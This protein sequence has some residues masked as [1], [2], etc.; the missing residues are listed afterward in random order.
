MSY[1]WLNGVDSSINFG[2]VNNNTNNN[3]NQ[4]GNNYN[5]YQQ[6]N[7]NQIQPLNSANANRPVP[8]P[9]LPNRQEQ[10][11]SNYNNNIQPNNQIS[12]VYGLTNNIHS[13]I[14]PEQ[15][16]PLPTSNSNSNNP[17]F[18][19]ALYANNTSGSSLIQQPQIPPQVTTSNSFD[20]IYGNQYLNANLSGGSNSN[21]T[22]INYRPP[23]TT[24][25]NL[26]NTRFSNS[27]LSNI[28]DTL[29]GSMPVN[30]PNI[31]RDN[32]STQKFTP[33]YDKI[34]YDQALNI[35]GN[36]NNNSSTD[37]LS[38]NSNEVK[39]SKNPFRKMMQN[40]SSQN[41]LVPNNSNNN[42]ENGKSQLSVDS[43]INKPFQVPD[44]FKSIV[45]EIPLSL[46]PQLLSSAEIKNYKRWFENIL[47]K[48]HLH[49]NIRLTDIFEFLKNNFVIPDRVKE[50][51]KKI[52]DNIRQ[53]IGLD[54]FYAIL[55]CLVVLIKDNGKIP[56]PNLLMQK[57]LPLLEPKSILAV[58]DGKEEVYEEVAD[59]DNNN[60]QSLDFDNFASL[61]M[62]GKSHR[63]KRVVKRNGNR[64]QNKNVKFSDKLVT[65][66]DEQIRP[67]ESEEAAQERNG[68]NENA[69]DD[70][71]YHLQ[72]TRNT[73][74]L[75]FS[76]P[77]EQLLEQLEGKK[78]TPFESQEEKDELADMQE[79]L[80]HF[81]NLPKIDTVSLSMNGA[82]SHGNFQHLQQQNIQQP[83]KPTATGSANYMMNSGSL[84]N[85]KKQPQF[86]QPTATGS[87]NR[88]FSNNS[89]DNVNLQQQQEASLSQ[90]HFL[91]PTAT[92]S[93]NHLFA[94]SNNN[95]NIFNT[96]FSNTTPSVSFNSNS[97]NSN[98]IAPD[99]THILGDLKS[100]QDQI[101]YISKQMYANQ[102]HQ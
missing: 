9:P 20:N 68:G 11:Y 98:N 41:V 35:F 1:E 25:S 46:A 52:F 76:L 37:I 43:N 5:A 85:D 100:I 91:Q 10:T 61:L 93:A 70:T 59:D 66:E 57:A 50:I 62:T 19:G 63:V 77:M 21:N 14:L 90:P 102:P 34:N 71:N 94:N 42:I 73:G 7:L 36:S 33:N 38:T 88:L 69:D 87:A 13:N 4:Y 39:A 16:S 27:P 12:S 48:K 64:V 22:T 3:N 28:Q 40:N 32:S 80:T 101:D 74:A 78:T 49:S 30:R 53:N 54:N 99:G 15:I 47:A 81:Q 51:V 84:H 86:L 60:V 31:S 56:S 96:S 67:D 17:Y 65:Y 45:S 83:L 29:G 24:L 89:I 18:P 2:N 82:I 8:P 44:T 92:G 26:H 58:N 97:N 55:R 75:D 95:N 23:E 72:N 6:P 79:S